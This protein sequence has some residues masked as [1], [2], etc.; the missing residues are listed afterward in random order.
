MTFVGVIEIAKSSET[1]RA[2]YF[3]AILLL[4]AMELIPTAAELSGIQFRAEAR[5]LIDFDGFY[6]AGQLVW[7]GAIEKAYH[8]AT[9]FPLQVSISHTENFQPWTYPPQFD[10][11]VA[12]LALLPLGLAYS[13][14]TL[15][16]LAAYLA[17][18]RRIAAENFVPI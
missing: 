16:T 13:V 11:L 3:R 5:N 8:F 14:F 6:I 7:Q 17:T 15:A 12:P 4:I 2:I 1:K 10:L 18:L 9:L